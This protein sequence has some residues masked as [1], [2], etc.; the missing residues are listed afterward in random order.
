MKGFLAA[1]AI[2]LLAIAAQPRSAAAAPDRADESQLTAAP[3]HQPS[4]AAV[5][6][7][8]LRPGAPEGAPQAAAAALE[9]LADLRAPAAAGHPSVLIAAR[10]REKYRPFLE[11]L[12][13]P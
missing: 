8:P 7:V 3:D 9:P 5:D 12:T 4:I 11:S 13:S 1:V 10:L 6:G 2:A